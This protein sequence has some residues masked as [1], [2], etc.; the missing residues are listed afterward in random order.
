MFL[1]TIYHIDIRER[2]KKKRGYE[3]IFANPNIVL[4][5]Y[6]FFFL[7]ISVILMLISRDAS[8]NLGPV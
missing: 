8:E 4:F 6:F 1:P 3:I 5:L 7:Y 2:R